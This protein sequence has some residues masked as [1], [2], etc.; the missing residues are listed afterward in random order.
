MKRAIGLVAVAIMCAFGC[1][2]AP[3][4]PGERAD[5]VRDAHRTLADMENRDPSLRPLIANSVG[6]IVFPSVGSG[7]FIVGGGAGSGVVFEHGRQT[8]FATVEHMAAGAIAGGQEYAQLVIVNDRTAMDDIRAGR[9]NF[10]ANASAVIIRTGAATNASFDR[11]V[12]V[13]REPIR[14]AMVNASLGGQR[15]RLSM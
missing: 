12:A 3:T 9:F 5:L 8:G 11:G 14:G 6:Y 4:K 10:S 7:G 15:I 13:F 2:T 1:A